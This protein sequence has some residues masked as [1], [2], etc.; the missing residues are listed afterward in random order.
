MPVQKFQ[1]PSPFFNKNLTVQVV[2]TYYHDLIY[3]LSFYSS[4]INLDRTNHF[5]GVQIILIQVKLDFFGLIFIIWTR[6]KQ[7]APVQDDWYSTKIIW[8]LQNHFGP[9]EGQGIRDILTAQRGHPMFSNKTN[10]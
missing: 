5:G 2:H 8:T 10:L 6:P 4:E 9:I 7:I 3:A 1:S